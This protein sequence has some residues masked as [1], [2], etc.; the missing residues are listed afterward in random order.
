MDSLLHHTSGSAVISVESRVLW[1]GVASHTCSGFEFSFPLSA[2]LI[3]DSWAEKWIHAF[4]KGISAK[5]NANSL[6][7]DLNLAW[8]VYF[9]LLHID[10]WPGQAVK[11]RNAPV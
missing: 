6:V 3:I 4:S 9:L 10:L 7:Q 2:W 11:R 1:G 5:W 8:Q